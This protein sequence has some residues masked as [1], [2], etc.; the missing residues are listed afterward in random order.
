MVIQRGE[1]WWATLPDPIAQ[2]PVIGG[3]C[4]WCNLM[5]SIAAELQL[6]L[7]W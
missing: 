2:A 3:P 5:T 7:R 1:I 6:L 4:W